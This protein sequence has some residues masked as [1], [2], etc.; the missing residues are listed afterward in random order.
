MVQR[1][2]IQMIRTCYVIEWYGNG[3]RYVA[4]T[5]LTGDGSGITGVS[6]N[7]IKSDDIAE[8]DA[9]VRSALPPVH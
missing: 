8:G 6:A 1:S 9:A 7:S 3:G 4:A 2:V 5:T